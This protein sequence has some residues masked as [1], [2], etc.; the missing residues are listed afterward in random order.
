MQQCLLFF[1][2]ERLLVK[3]NIFTDLEDINNYYMCKLR[4][5]T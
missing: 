1:R 5:P 2:K 3:E 4:M